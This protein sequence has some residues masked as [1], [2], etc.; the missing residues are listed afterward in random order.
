MIDTATADNEPGR[1]LGL[2]LNDQLGQ[3]PEDK[4]EADGR[5]WYFEGQ[6]GAED[7]AD[8]AARLDLVRER[9]ALRLMVT[10]AYGKLHSRQFAS[11]DDALEVDRI[12][13]YVVHGVLA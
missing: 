11:I 13:L 8:T 4:A 12:A 3:L 6:H 10:W 5:N 2:P 1:P 7:A 9:D